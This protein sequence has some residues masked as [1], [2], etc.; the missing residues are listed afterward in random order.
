M[1]RLTIDEREIEVPEGATLLEAARRLEIE[2]PTLCYLEGKEPLTTCLVCVVKDRARGKLVPACAT[3][4]V[5]GMVIESETQEVY[6]TR[7]MALEL[8][9]SDHVGDCLAPC[10]FACPA[11]MDVPLM[12]RQ[13]AGRD[14]ASAIVTVKHDIALPAVLG[15]IC[16]KPCEKGCRRSGADGA[17]AVCQLKRMVADAD[18]ASAQPYRPQCAP[19]TGKRVAVVGGG[20]AGLSAAYFLAQQGHRVTVFDRRP[21]PGGRLWDETTEAE[22]PRDVLLAEVGAILALGVEFRGETEVGRDIAVDTVLADCDALLL[23]CGAGAAAEGEAWGVH[24]SQR[25]IEADRHTYQTSRPGVFAAGN[26][27]RGKALAVRSLADGKE[28]AHAIHQFLAGQSVTGTPEEFSVRMGRVGE[29]ELSVFL[30]LA[31]VAARRD[32]PAEG[33]RLADGAA[34]QASRCLHCDCRSRDACKLRT[35]AA[36]Y[37]ADPKHYAGQRRSFEQR[38]NAS[39]VVYEPGKCIGCGIC[40]QIAALAG[41]PLGLAFIGRGFDVRVDAPFDRSIDEALQRAAAEC[42]AA[43]PTGAIAWKE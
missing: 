3:R 38:T 39:G 43:C 27:V 6:A 16:P 35:Y 34:E 11:H 10:Q 28:A 24:T 8:L 18:L 25:G 23:A 17:V 12:L 26:A 30:P 37:G 40:V 4:A 7:R 9:L 19:P 20:P 33:D 15:R 31:S 42:I 5:D 1:P 32:L 2:I 21:Q 36:R 22:L 41:E 29:Q 13:I 14:L